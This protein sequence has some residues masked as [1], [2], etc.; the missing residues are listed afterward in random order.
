MAMTAIGDLFHTTATGALAI[1]HV[2]V[3]VHGGSVYVR[4]AKPTPASGTL[5]KKGW[6]AVKKLHDMMFRKRTPGT[7][8]GM[9]KDSHKAVMEALLW[10]CCNPVTGI[11]DA[12][13]ETIAK[14]AHMTVQTLHARLKDLRAWGMIKWQPRCDR[15][16]DT[17]RLQQETNLYELCPP[18]KWLFQPPD[19][20]APDYH[21]APQ[22][23]PE[24]L[25]LAAQ[26]TDP[27][28]KL[29]A[30]GTGLPRSQGGSGIEQALFALGTAGLQSGR[31]T[32]DEQ[33]A[34]A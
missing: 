4:D 12:A 31:W 6:R 17:G 9:F 13:L 23:V 22:R 10:H 2:S 1:G 7:H 20:P 29:A 14:A 27:V 26:E 34:P 15:D 11:M 33:P 32:D 19:A 21:G 24:P 5:R 16:K 28:A 18:D 3:P 8:G 25:E 30:L